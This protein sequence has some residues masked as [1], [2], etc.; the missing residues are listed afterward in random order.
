MTT[1]QTPEWWAA[2]IKHGAYRGGQ[3]SPTHYVWR[4]MLARSFNPKCKAYPRYGGQGI[5]ACKRW[6]KYENFLADMGERPEGLELE[7]RD[8]DKGYSP[9]NCY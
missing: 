7:R 4:S 3:E 5:V 2:R 9:A 6:L 1:W 8:N